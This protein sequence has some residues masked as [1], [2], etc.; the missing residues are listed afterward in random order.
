MNVRFGLNL[1]AYTA[2]FTKD[3]IG[4]VQKAA[5]IGF[6]GVEIPFPDLSILDA[7]ATRAACEKAGVGLT[8]CCIM[9][10]GENLCSTDPKERKAGL[11]RIKKMADLTAEMCGHGAA[12]PL[13]T[14]VGHHTGQWRTPDEWKWCAEGLR[15]AADH[16][17]KADVTLCVEPLNRFETYFLNIYADVVT[18]CKEVGS[19]NLKVH[20]DTFHANIEEKDTPAAIRATG[21]LVGHF[22]ASE[23]DRGIPGTGQVRWKEVFAALKA[24]G[25]Q[26]W[27][28][29]ESFA[30]GIMDLCAAAFIWRP[31]CKSADELATKGLA[32]L[33]KTVAE[34]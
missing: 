4:L 2:A 5:D 18:L 22:H 1:F 25:Y 9:M 30:P 17:A 32:F 29:I 10:P 24:I 15:A 21:A 6:D 11:T 8:T 31:L 12:G 13:Y 34:V 3:Q 20:V 33:K 27:V 14:P 28:T 19:P 7:K 26:G 16:A 23:S